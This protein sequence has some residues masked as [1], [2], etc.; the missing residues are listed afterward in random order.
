MG[1]SAPPSK[2]FLQDIS[3]VLLGTVPRTVFTK[4][5]N[6]RALVSCA[7]LK[8]FGRMLGC[9]LT[10]LS[11]EQNYVLGKANFKVYSTKLAVLQLL[12]SSSSTLKLRGRTTTL[13]D[14]ERAAVGNISNPCEMET[15][16]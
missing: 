12:R 1:P 4:L 16:I 8:L 11:N 7:Q 5:Q 10:F 2:P 15:V 3:S 13:Q 14:T 6:L 9:A